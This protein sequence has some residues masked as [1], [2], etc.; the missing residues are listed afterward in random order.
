MVTR[1]IDFFFKIFQGYPYT[2]KFVKNVSQQ[3][4]C[5]QCKYIVLTKMWLWKVVADI[6]L[7]FLLL[8][9]QN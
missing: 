9:N 1:W 7:N 3:N 4:P 8:T 5:S 2:P 6:E